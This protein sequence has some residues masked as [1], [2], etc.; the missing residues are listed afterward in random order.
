MNKEILPTS[1]PETND[2]IY[3]GF[4]RRAGA[5]LLDF[6]FMLPFSIGFVLINNQG[7]LNYLY[8]I[9]PMSIFSLVYFTYPVQRWGGTPGKLVFGIHILKQNGERVRWNEAVLRQLP[10]FALGI[11]GIIAQVVTL[12]GISDSEYLL[13]F[14]ER[15]HLMMEERPSW[16]E[17]PQWANNL[18]VIIGIIVM[19]SNER[20]R[21]VHDFFAGTVVINKKHI[22]ALNQHLHSIVDS[23]GPE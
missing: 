5:L 7:R 16:A 21:A 6:F 18:W 22:P 9:V 23:A 11:F 4:W 8:T 10:V 15:A 1:I 12:M 20:R 3:A 19:L 14:S 17:Y 2:R 13:P